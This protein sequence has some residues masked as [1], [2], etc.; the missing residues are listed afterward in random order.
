MQ[1][2]TAWFTAENNEFDAEN[3]EFDALMSHKIAENIKAWDRPSID[4]PL[5]Q[6]NWEIQQKF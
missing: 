5:V 3:N 4:L 2:Y 6:N 1:C